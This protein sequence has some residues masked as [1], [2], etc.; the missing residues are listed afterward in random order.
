MYCGSHFPP[1]PEPTLRISIFEIPAFPVAASCLE[2]PANEF[3]P[4]ERK[5]IDL[6]G[7]LVV[8]LSLLRQT[9][10]LCLLPEPFADGIPLWHRLTRF[11][12][13]LA[14]VATSWLGR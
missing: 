6:R 4:L 14:F 11:R 10:V 8:L 7:M 2:T 5:R 3:S 9:S 1:G 12:R 13:S